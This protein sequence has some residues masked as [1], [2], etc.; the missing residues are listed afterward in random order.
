MSALCAVHPP[1]AETRGGAAMWHHPRFSSSVRGADL[2]VQ[3]LYTLLY[4]SGVDL[5]ISGHNHHYERFGTL[6]PAGLFDP[7]GIRQFVV[8][9]GGRSLYRFRSDTPGS[10][11]RI[12]NS[13]GVMRLELGPG[14]YQWMFWPTK[15]FG[16]TDSGWALCH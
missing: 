13:H 16:G 8:G 1:R 4:D 7:N 6:S 11:A 3:D 12:R 14:G 2:S 15:T 10:E 5:L 9:T